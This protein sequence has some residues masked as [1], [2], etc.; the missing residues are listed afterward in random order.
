MN[1]LDDIVIADDGTE[2]GRLSTIDGPDDADWDEASI[3]L[4]D[5]ERSVDLWN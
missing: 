3:E 1:I 4:D 5:L 2:L